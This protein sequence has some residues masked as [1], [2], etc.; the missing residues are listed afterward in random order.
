MKD[1]PFKIS[2]VTFNDYITCID[3]NQT[4]LGS[5]LAFIIAI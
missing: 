5:T 2:P 1:K 3:Y 4:H